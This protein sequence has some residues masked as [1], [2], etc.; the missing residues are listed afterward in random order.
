M[1]DRPQARRASGIE[2]PPDVTIGTTRGRTLRIRTATSSWYEMLSASFQLEETR[3]R[4]I[5]ASA[6]GQSL[7]SYRRVSSVRAKSGFLNRKL[8]QR[9]AMFSPK[10]N[11]TPNRKKIVYIEVAGCKIPCVYKIY[12]VNTITIVYTWNRSN[13][14][15][16][17]GKTFSVCLNIQLYSNSVEITE[18]NWPSKNVLQESFCSYNQVFRPVPILPRQ[19]NVQ[20]Y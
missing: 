19:W 18:N 20:L 6:R 14:K 16:L 1:R 5:V 17:H 8:N 13:R 12:D 2:T 9:R 7:S 3:Q 15:I 10:E 11:A 4:K